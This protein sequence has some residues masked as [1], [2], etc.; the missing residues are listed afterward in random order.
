MISVTITRTELVEHFACHEGLAFFDSVEDGGGTLT[1][2]NWTPLHTVML[3]KAG[4]LGWCCRRD[5]VPLANLRNA[6]LRGADLP[7]VRLLGADLTDADLTG[8][9]LSGVDWRNVNLRYADLSHARLTEADLRRANLEGAR[10]CG[11][12]VRG[13]NLWHADRLPDDDEIPG[14]RLV[15]GRLVRER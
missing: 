15:D 11:A 8:A 1:I 2:Q 6:D 13:A 14:W 9:D 3:A 10:L 12:D 4:W 7:K 5:V